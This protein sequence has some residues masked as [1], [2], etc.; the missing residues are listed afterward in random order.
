LNGS[1]L[2][3]FSYE[4]IKEQRERIKLRNTLDR[5]ISQDVAGEI[6]ESRTDFYQALGGRRKPV[7]VFFADIRSFTTLSEQRTPEQM[8]SQ[9]NEYLTP[10]VSLIQE[11]RGRLDK[12]I[13]DEIMAVWGDL[14]EESDPGLGARRAVETALSM[15]EKLA[16]LNERW[17]KRGDPQLAFGIGINHGEA[18]FGNLGAEQRMELTVIGDAV[19]LAARLQGTTKQYGIDLAVS[20]SV[21]ELTE[22]EFIY[23]S[24]DLVTVKGK[25]EPTEIFSA[26]GRRGKMLTPKWLD[27]YEYGI[28]MY[29]E[30]N[31][32]E[33][34]KGFKRCEED[35]QDDGLVQ[36]YV[37]RCQELIDDPPGDDWSPV[38][39]LTSK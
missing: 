24:I 16:E 28:K 33:A 11:N 29:R 36:L 2:S 26:I 1:G 10:M 19:N 3:L 13:G 17:E 15:R 35:L 34:L 4:Y 30:G 23:R 31:F 37:E 9:L 7:T 8:V 5:Y 25:T 27:K 32:E 18:L 22:D 14:F 20:E 39:G 6:L 38:L 21:K 12:F